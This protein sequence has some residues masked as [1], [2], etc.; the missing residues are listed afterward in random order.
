MNKSWNPVLNLIV[1]IK[2]QYFNKFKS[3]GNYKLETWIEE[4]NI[5]KYIDLFD[6]LQ[7]NQ[8]DKIVLI[9]YGIAEMQPSMWADKNSIYRECRSV[10]IDLK[11]E[12]IV[13]CPFRKFFNINEV[14]ENNIDIIS[15]EIKNAKIVEIT[16][17]L[18]GSMQSARYYNNQY[19]M[20]GGMALD[21]KDSWRLQDGYNMLSNKY[22]TMLRENSDFTFIFEYISLNDAHVVLYDKSQEGLYLIGI[23][24]V[25]SGKE[26]SYEE[27]KDYSI[28]YNIPMTNIENKTFDDVLKEMKIYKS[29]E[30]EG[31]VL[32]IDGHKMKIKCDDYVHLHRLL[33][34][35]SSINVIIQNIADDKYDDMIS[36]IPESYRNRIEKIAT[37]ILNYKIKTENMV[38]EF[39]FKAPKNDKKDFMIWVDTNCSNRINGYVKC[40][41]L[42]QSFNVLKNRHGGYKKIKDLGIVEDYSA[43]FCDMEGE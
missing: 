11:N 30:K 3:Y 42:N 15:E 40:K 22:K 41:F 23:R 6:C 28:R 18:D 16:N 37:K 20:A 39:Y 31:W 34:K 14:S 33:D 29:N 32:N 17:K 43:L 7:V 13:L 35:V 8:K 10:V 21:T 4:L 5:K 1:D 24:D 19:I 2:E 27:I 38:E 26:L 25:L 9:R 36:K 12:C